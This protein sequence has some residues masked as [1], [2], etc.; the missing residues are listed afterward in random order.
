VLQIGQETEQKIITQNIIKTKLRFDANLAKIDEKEDVANKISNAIKLSSQKR[1]LTKTRNQIAILESFLSD[2][3]ENDKILKEL[4]DKETKLH[5][6]VV[7][8]DAKQNNKQLTEDDI[9]ELEQNIEE[10]NNS[11]SQ[12]K[13]SDTASN[14]DTSG[15]SDNGSSDKGS[16]DKGSSDKGSSD[17][18]S[19]DKGKSDKGNKGNSNNKGKSKK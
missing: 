3:D 10:E 11:K 4:R 16:S 1:D 7:I 6:S 18:G 2:S 5:K 17:K 13:T 9:N 19:S 15:Q 8:L 12:S 14:S